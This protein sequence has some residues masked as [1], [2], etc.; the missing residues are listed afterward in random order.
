MFRLLKKRK[1]IKRSL[2]YFNKKRIMNQ[3]R[4]LLL[5]FTIPVVFFVACESK[6]GAGNT[7]MDNT[8]SKDTTN[9]GTD[10][11]TGAT[12]GSPGGNAGA[13]GDAQFLMKGA[14]TDMTEIKSSEAALKKTKN[15]TVTQVANMMIEEHTKMSQLTKDLASRKNVTLPTTLPAEKQAMLEKAAGLEGKDF[16]KEYI[17]QLIAGHTEAVS[18]LER[19]ST[20]ATDPDIKNWA[21]T[22][23][24][25]VK[26]HLQMV[27]EAQQKI[28]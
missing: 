17:S 15:P 16:E 27:K 14:E 12:T 11:N 1:K 13:T 25:K 18:M 3:L 23:L 20:E 22:A 24:P 5:A 2:I 9:Q 7:S 19:A 28:K 6:T 21:T 26:M 4:S 10:V 8:Q